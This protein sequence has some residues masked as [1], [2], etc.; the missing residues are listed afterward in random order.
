MTAHNLDRLLT[1]LAVQLHPTSVCRIAQGWRLAFGAFEAVTVHHVLAGAGIVRIGQGPEQAYAPGSVIIVPPRQSHVVGDPGSMTREVMAED[2][3]GSFADG[4]AAFAAGDGPGTLLLC[5]SIP[6]S[7]GRA[8]AVFDFLRGAEVQAP[9]DDVGRRSFDLMRA[10]VAAP[11]L[12]TAAVTEALMKACLVTLLRG[13]LRRGGHA[14]ALADLP[15]DPRLARAVLA[16]LEEPGA[17]HTVASLAELAGMSRAS[18]A[19]HFARALGGGPMEFVQGVRLRAAARLLETTALPLKVVAA[20]VGYG[21]ATSLSRAFRVAYGLDPAAYR[22]Q[23]RGRS[24]LDTAT[25]DGRL[26]SASLRPAEQ[27]QPDTSG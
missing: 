8:L 19:G 6:S 15:G 5:G 21:G 26:V 7:H 27:D 24:L 25:V 11:G 3:C 17:P 13:H 16:V 12:G 4:L 2:H 22:D 9:D 18:F 14:G 23:P 10:E 1:A 20:A